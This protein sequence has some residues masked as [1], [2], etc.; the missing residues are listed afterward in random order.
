MK[1][2]GL[3][4]LPS[5]QEVF[6]CLAKYPK[7]PVVMF[8]DVIEAE[9]RTASESSV[10][11]SAG[12]KFDM[13]AEIDPESVMVYLANNSTEGMELL[14][15]LNRFLRGARATGLFEAWRREAYAA[16]YEMVA[17]SCSLELNLV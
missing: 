10:L 8:S 11:S 17:A 12:A 7:L 1:E 13:P 15:E 9:F 16:K 2:A 3:E 5:T 6:A 14:S 4:I